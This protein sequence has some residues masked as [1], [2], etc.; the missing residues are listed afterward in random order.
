MQTKVFKSSM[1]FN[2]TQPGKIND[3]GKK[4]HL[5]SCVKHRFLRY[6]NALEYLN[7][8]HKV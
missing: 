2:S 8:A 5:K 6:K 7:E 3:L 1:L 4:M